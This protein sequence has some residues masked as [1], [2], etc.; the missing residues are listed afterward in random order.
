WRPLVS[1]GY[2]MQLVR[3]PTQEG[4]KRQLGHGFG[5]EALFPLL[6]SGRR[7]SRTRLS[8]ALGFGVDYGEA[9]REEPRGS[10]GDRVVTRE[11]S[12]W[13]HGAL[14]LVLRVR[15]APR[16]AFVSSLAWLPGVRWSRLD[17]R[18]SSGDPYRPGFSSFE[19]M[20][21]GVR[22]RNPDTYPNLTH[23]RAAF[24]IVHRGVRLG[25]FFGATRRDDVVS[26][27]RGPELELGTQMGVGW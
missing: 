26:W 27:R 6:S 22:T 21:I 2:R 9:Q 7:A 3:E 18:L 11:R 20:L 16:W 25:V 4:V 23:G 13:F 5:F 10:D 17:R 14:A 8:I 15:L 19:P 24:S 12:A 1:V